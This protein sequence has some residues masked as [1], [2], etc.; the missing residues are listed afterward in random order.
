[1]RMYLEKSF[2]LNCIL[3]KALVSKANVM[4]EDGNGKVVKQKQ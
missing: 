3:Q 1:M 2:A 4:D